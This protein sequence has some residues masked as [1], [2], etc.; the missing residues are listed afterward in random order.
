MK[1]FMNRDLNIDK[2]IMS[3]YFASKT[4]EPSQKNRKN[5]ALLYIVNAERTYSFND[6]EEF[7]VKNGD[8]LFIPK[9]HP[10]TVSSKEIREGYAICFETK[11]ANLEPFILRP[12]NS[13]Y[14][15]DSFK[16]ASNA[17]SNKSIGY[18]MRC[19]AEL[20]NIIC[21][22]QSEYLLTYVSQSTKNRLSPALEYIHKE[23]TKDNLSIPY[24]ADLCGMSE[25][26]FRRHFKNSMGLSPLKYINNLKISRAKELLSFGECSVIE[27][28]FLSGFHDECYFSRTFKKYTGVSPTE[29]KK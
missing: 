24:L 3:Y 15:L 16:T 11:E 13:S 19:K 22:M 29:Y 25:V 14:F 17:W 18:Q 27:A 12:K 5:H 7:N 8:L 28:A 10:Y 21:N 6:G 26:L 9:E 20:Y 2:I 1:N 23:Y 4:K